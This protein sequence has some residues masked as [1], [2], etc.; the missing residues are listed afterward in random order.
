MVL[1]PCKEMGI[2]T[3]VG[4]GNTDYRTTTPTAIFA[5]YDNPDDDGVSGS[6]KTVFGSADSKLACELQA[7][8]RSNSPHVTTYSLNL[9]IPVS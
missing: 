1:V 9:R 6:G 7:T 8:Y 5:V 3:A 2:R 4:R